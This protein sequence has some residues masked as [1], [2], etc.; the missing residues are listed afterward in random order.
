MRDENQDLR[1]CLRLLQKE[2]MDIVNFKQEMF[3]KRFKAEYGSGRE[4][5]Q[6]TQEALTHK[7]ELIRDELFNAN[8]EE[9]GRE[10]VQKFRLN[11]QRLKEFMQTIDK[12]VASLAIFN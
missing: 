1:E 4:V 2:I 7:I 8:F 9:N 10:L 5:G 6:E 12:E 3:G 11:F